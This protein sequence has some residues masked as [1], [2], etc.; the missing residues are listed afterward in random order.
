VLKRARPVAEARTPKPFPSR[1]SND[2]N[3]IEPG[4]LVRV[5]FFH[6]QKIL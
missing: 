3:K 2:L 5:P 4:V 1:K 6:L